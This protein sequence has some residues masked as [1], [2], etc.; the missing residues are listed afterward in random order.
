MDYFKGIEIIKDLKSEFRKLAKMFHPDLNKEKDGSEMKEILNQF[1]RYSNL[2]ETESKK[3]GAYFQYSSYD[4]LKFE[5]ELLEKII[6]LSNMKMKEVEIELIGNWI[7][8]FGNSKP[9]RLELKKI[10]FK[11]NQKRVAWFYNVTPYRKK[12]NKT[13]PTEALKILYGN[14]KID[15]DEFIQ[16]SISY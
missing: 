5:K 6:L 16:K 11:W 8:I 3:Q 7:W 14:K 4:E 12:T 9:Y 13:L 10:G 1:K 15:T 2:F